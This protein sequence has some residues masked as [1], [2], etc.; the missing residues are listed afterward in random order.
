MYFAACSRSHLRFLCVHDR[1]WAKV[2]ESLADIGFV[3]CSVELCFKSLITLI[4][5]RY[6]P[7]SMLMASYDWRMAYPQLEQR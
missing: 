6:D 2:I 7:N 5:C 1:V 4:I 3:L